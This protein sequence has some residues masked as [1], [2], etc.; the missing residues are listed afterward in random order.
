MAYVDW[1]IKGPKIG[2]CSCS[3]GC[4]CEFN[5]RPTHG[6][7][8]GLEAHRIDEGWFGEV[9]LDGLV[10]GARYR[11]PGPVHEGGGTVQGF[12]DAK[13]SDAQRQALFAILG[14]KEQE[15]TT[16][17]NI[18]AST[19]AKE[20]DPVFGDFTFA[21]DFEKRTGRFV[22]P[23]LLEMS[24]EP[25][26]NP[27]TGADHFAQIVLPRGFEFHTGE[28]ASAD[29]KATGGEL[30]MQR[31]KCYGVLTY[32]A[33]GPHGIIRDKSVIPRAA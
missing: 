29:F 26:K 2:A 1:M 17:F 11:W 10:I 28:M 6:L 30:A 32:A 3:Y 15:P 27:V 4:P 16:V 19:I 25:I 13:A 18:Y 5:A 31:A 7:C 9:R 33:Y 20:L 21:C 23:G 14:G 24:L 12:L 8:E 22:A